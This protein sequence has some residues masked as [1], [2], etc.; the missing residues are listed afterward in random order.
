MWLNWSV[1][2]VNATLQLL[3]IYIDNAGAKSMNSLKS[4]NQV[5]HHL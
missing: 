3:D 4:D 5:N 2:T 1:V